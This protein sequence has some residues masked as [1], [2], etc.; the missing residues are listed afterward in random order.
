MAMFFSSSSVRSSSI[1]THA[2]FY[3]DVQPAATAPR[4]PWFKAVEDYDALPRSLYPILPPP[5]PYYARAHP[6][7]LSR[8]SSSITTYRDASMMEV[9]NYED[10]D[11]GVDGTPLDATILDNYTIVSSSNGRTEFEDDNIGIDSCDIEDEYSSSAFEVDYEPEEDALGTLRATRA[12]CMQ[13][14]KNATRTNQAANKRTSPKR[15]TKAG[16]KTT[17]EKALASGGSASGGTARRTRSS[18][19]SQQP[20][21]RVI[22][23]QGV[24]L[25]PLTE[26]G[27]K[28]RKKWT[29]ANKAT[30][31]TAIRRWWRAEGAASYHYPRKIMVP[32]GNK[33]EA[34]MLI[35]AECK[36][37][38]PNFNHTKIGIATVARDMRDADL[39]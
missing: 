39:L 19:S 13:G 33:D 8:C 30:L 38:N 9:Q 23:Y 26:R 25:S 3:T 24:D 7:V 31:L 27:Y 37:L 15:T 11:E 34:W 36:K 21:A 32:S 10:E 20:K 5:H 35:W 29:P 18:A 17:S 22:G 2:A 6:I 16:K 1:E 28:T 14:R 12:P 4:P